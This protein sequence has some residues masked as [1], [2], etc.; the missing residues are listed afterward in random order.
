MFYLVV[1][2]KR[3]TTKYDNYVLVSSQ[4][5]ENDDAVPYREYAGYKYLTKQKQSDALLRAYNLIAEGVQT[6]KK[7]IVLYN[8]NFPLTEEELKEVFFCYKLDYPQSFWIDNGYD[9]VLYKDFVYSIFPW[10][11]FSA[12]ELPDAKAMFREKAKEILTKVKDLSLEEKELFIHDYLAYNVSFPSAPNQSDVSSAYSAIVEGIADCDGF[13]NAFTLLIRE[14]GIPCKTVFGS[15]STGSSREN[16]A[17][18]VVSLYEQEF[19]VDVTFDRIQTPSEA[20]VSHRY[21][22]VS[23]EVFEKDHFYG[24]LVLQE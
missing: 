8:V 21:F 24:C 4:S 1:I 5:I 3:F 6:L 22:N 10:Y 11:T 18:N 14:C 13:A 16:H 15:A 17:W 2:E 7:S 23:Q 20:Y 19:Y 12:E 9:F